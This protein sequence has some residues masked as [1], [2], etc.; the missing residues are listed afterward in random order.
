MAFFPAGIADRSLNDRG[1]KNNLTNGFS[2]RSEYKLYVTNLPAELNEDGIRQIF[3]SYGEVTGIM[4]PPNV[5]WA[6]VTYRTHREAVLAIG[7][8]DDKSPLHL[9]VEFSKDRPSQNVR[10]WTRQ[11]ISEPVIPVETTFAPD[12]RD[13]G[14]FIQR[15]N[16]P[17]RKLEVHLPERMRSRHLVPNYDIHDDIIYPVEH[18]P[19]TLNPFENALPYSESNLLWTR[20]RLGVTENGRRHVYMGRGYTVYQIPEPYPRMEENISSM[21]GRR[22]NGLYEYGEDQLKN[23]V[24]RCE[25]CGN[26]TKMRCSK[27]SAFYC[28]RSCQK[29]DWD[30]HKVECQ[31]L[32]SLS[33]IPNALSD[34]KEKELKE[35]VTMLNQKARE[36]SDVPLRAPHSRVLEAEQETPAVPSHQERQLRAPHQENPVGTSPQR[37]P[38]RK[39]MQEPSHQENHVEVPQEIPVQT[40]PQREKPIEVPQP[41]SAPHKPRID[42]EKVEEDLAFQKKSFLSKDKF[43]EVEIMVPLK[44]ASYWVQRSEDVK[45]FAALMS[46]LEKAT[47]NAPKAKPVVGSLIACRYCHI[48]HRASI[49]SVDPLIVHYIDYGNDE[50]LEND[51]IRTLGSFENIPRLARQI[52]IQKG[53]GTIFDGLSENCKLKVKMISEDAEGVIT[54]ITPDQEIEDPVKPLSSSQSGSGSRKGPGSHHSQNGPSPQKKD[55]ESPRDISSPKNPPPVTNGHAAEAVDD[56]DDLVPTGSVLDNLDPKDEGALEFHTHL[57]KNK[58]TGTIVPEKLNLFYQKILCQV[59]KMCEIVSRSKSYQPKKVGEYILGKREDEDWVRGRVLSVG[60]PV[61]VAVVDEGRVSLLKHCLD[62]TSQPAEICTFGAV[63]TL[64]EEGF[65]VEKAEP[66]AFTVL[67]PKTID[68][69]KGIE[70]I[71]S[72][73]GKS[74]HAFLTKWIPPPEQVGIQALE[75]KPNTEVA[76]TAYRSQSLI[77]VRSLENDQMEY[78]NR[79]LQDVSKEAQTAPKLKDIPVVGEMVFAKFQ[80]DGNYY[81]AIVSKIDGDK[82]MIMYVDFG[83]T[84]TSS[85]KDMLIMSDDLKKRTSGAGKIVLKGVPK[86]VPM[87]QELSQ[88]FDML[89]ERT[90]PLKITFDGIP[91][92]D[93]VELK[94]ASNESINEKVIQLLTPNWKKAPGEKNCFELK[95]L[96]VAPLG[97]EGDVVS[98]IVLHTQDEGLDYFMCPYDI[99]LVSHV[100]DVL[101]SLIQKYVDSGTEHYIPRDLELCIAPFEGCWYR[102]ACLARN[103]TPTESSVFFVDYGNIVQVKHTDLRLM[104]EDFMTPSALASICRVKNLFPKSMENNLSEALKKRLGELLVP[105]SPAKVKIVSVDE[106]NTYVVEL[107]EIRE[108]LLQEKL[109]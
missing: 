83:N 87:T 17:Q 106:E 14:G 7:S 41:K 53:Q 75:I 10:D 5:D 3:N 11:N 65:V 76:I 68:G 42:Y 69:E 51:D 20:G 85:V 63:I 99:E 86:D 104:T 72:S 62:L 52:C 95:D 37:S 35:R 57:G 36:R 6:F 13:S 56:E 18:D 15:P 91:S 96:P 44:D 78:F 4:S 88:Y 8:L 25:L 74:Y 28:T 19:R 108:I 84:E 92:E 31:S 39:P 27:C 29:A 60:P 54:V 21:Y 107:P 55:S 71:I 103:V 50:T 1:P 30:R 43:T 45:E 98:V 46:N 34:I 61:K 40:P 101:P 49:V 23:E 109:I 12:Y 22:S 64:L 67:S 105:N 70:V 102:A 33:G 100:S 81:R 73:N 80:G 90:Q 79:L 77:Y 47:E 58:Y 16:I 24:G 38:L 2:E 9:K 48:W 82:I 59:P 97:K 93:G 94:T 66:Y 26:I 32:P 89:V